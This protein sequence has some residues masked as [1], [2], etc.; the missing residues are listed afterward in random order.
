MHPTIAQDMRDIDIGHLVHNFFDPPTTELLQ[1]TDE[2]QMQD[3][4]FAESLFN[5]Q[6]TMSAFSGMGNGSGGQHTQQ[7]Q[8]QP[9]P[10]GFGTG[11]PILDA[12][13][14]SFVEQLGF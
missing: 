13:W 11:A 10:V 6:P 14:Q 7:Q 8:Q 12:T 1:T 9:S 5:Q 3:V 2:Q 4:H